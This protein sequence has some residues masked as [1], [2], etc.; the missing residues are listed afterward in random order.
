MNPPS[1]S[2]HRKFKAIAPNFETIYDFIMWLHRHG[3]SIEGERVAERPNIDKILFKFFEI[4]KALLEQEEKE[5]V[6]YLLNP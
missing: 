6:E 5:A 3:Y 2:E 4:D 1:L